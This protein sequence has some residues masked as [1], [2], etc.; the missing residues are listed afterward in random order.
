MTH[1]GSGARLF[2]EGGPTKH[3]QLADSKI[4]KNG[5]AILIYL[6]AQAGKPA[7]T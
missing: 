5:V 1:P 4:A 2:H 7:E 6:P 3:L